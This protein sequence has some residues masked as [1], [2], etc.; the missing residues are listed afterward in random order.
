M[1]FARETCCLTMSDNNLICFHLVGKAHATGGCN[2][3]LFLPPSGGGKLGW[4]GFVDLGQIEF[5]Q[6]IEPPP[7]LS[8]R[9]GEGVGYR[10]KRG[11]LKTLRFGFLEKPVLHPFSGDLIYSIKTR[12]E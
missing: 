12:L 2:G 11:R 1:G 5:V 3:N 8:R 6:P 4:G 7:A 9:T 10:L